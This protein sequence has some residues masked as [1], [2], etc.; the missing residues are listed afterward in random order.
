MGIGE[1][2]FG[3]GIKKK[4]HYNN[5]I[6]NIKFSHSKNEIIYISKENSSKLYFKNISSYKYFK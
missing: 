3:N 1:W 4:E 2:G 6:K 5:F